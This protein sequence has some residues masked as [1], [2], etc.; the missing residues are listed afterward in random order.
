MAMDV[1]L[2]RC[3]A[4]GRVCWIAGP[5]TVDGAHGFG[6]RMRISVLWGQARRCPCLLELDA[7]LPNPL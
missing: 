6:C 1:V 7:P 4:P 5:R 3:S 2:T